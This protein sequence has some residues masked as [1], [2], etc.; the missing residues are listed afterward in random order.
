MH[1]AFCTLFRYIRNFECMLIVVCFRYRSNQ[2]DRRSV[3]SDR[4]APR[5]R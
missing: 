2:S 4:P 3:P 5:W 1:Q